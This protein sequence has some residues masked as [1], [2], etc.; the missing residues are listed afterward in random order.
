MAAYKQKNTLI[1][2]ERGIKDNGKK[3]E[4]VINK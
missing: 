3:R 4:R 2:I 1:F